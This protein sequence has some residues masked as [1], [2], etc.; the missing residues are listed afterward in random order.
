MKFELA[1]LEGVI[2]EPKGFLEVAKREG[3]VMIADDQ[4]WEKA[5]G[6]ASKT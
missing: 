4:E 2:D 6:M 1:N 5:K 3:V